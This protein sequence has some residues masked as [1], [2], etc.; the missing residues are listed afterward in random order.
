MTQ[1]TPEELIEFVRGRGDLEL[2]TLARRKAFVVRAVGDGLKY[3]PH[4][5]QEPRF[6]PKK[7]LARVCEKFSRTNS[8]HSNDYKMTVNAPYVLAII[9]AYLKSK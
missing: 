9:D 8:L 2:L 7:W 1:I 5:T 6:H 4:S 3:V